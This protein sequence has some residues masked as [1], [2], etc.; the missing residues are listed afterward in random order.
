MTQKGSLVA[1]DR[2]RFDFAHPEAVAPAALRTIESEVNDRI[3]G[4]SEV[5]TTLMDPDT[6]IAA[7]AM[8]LFGEKY[9][10]E[11]RVVCMG[12]ADPDGARNAWSVELCGGTHVTRTGDIGVFRILSEGAV[13]SGVRR[14]EA[15][16]GAAALAYLD[17]RDELL[18]RAAAQ[19]RATPDQLPERIGALVE[20]RRQLERELRDLRLRLASGGAS[21]GEQARIGDIPLITRTL[22]GVPAR[23]LRS[24]ADRLRSEIGSGVITI[25]TTDAGKASLV[26]AVTDDLTDRLDAVVLARAAAGALG[27]G[28]GG[29][30]PDLAQAGG[31][32]TGATPAALAAV[33]QALAD[34]TQS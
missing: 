33:R 12:G 31:P 10:E 28:G 17:G 23:E 11:V 21:N 3:R 20:E 16:T 4:N 25:I 9:G 5:T 6:A 13:A 30:R 18:E 2:L 34:A 22:E 19:V 26:V 32:D 15:V 7:G 24:M 29:G 14:I 27:G 8:A 1:P